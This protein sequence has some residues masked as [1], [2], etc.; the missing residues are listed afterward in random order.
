MF[1]AP[2]MTATRNRIPEKWQ[3]SFEAYQEKM[4]SG[5]VFGGAWLLLITVSLYHIS[6]TYFHVH[7]ADLGRTEL[8]SRLP[9]VTASLLALCSHWT[10]LP[11]WPARCFRRLM[12]WR[13]AGLALSL[14]FLFSKHDPIMVTQVS[15]AMT[16]A[17]FG[18]TVMALRCFTEWL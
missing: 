3:P 10:A 9:L 7:D 15:D 14:L 4:E 18:A 1:G 16:I 8:L 6:H 12:G 13:C 2:S 11:R 17:R 5:L